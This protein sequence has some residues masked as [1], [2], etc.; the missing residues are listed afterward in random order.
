[1]TLSAVQAHARRVLPVLAALSIAGFFFRFTAPSLNWYFSSDDSM[2]LY[3]S[4]YWPIGSLYRANFLFFLN[5][6]FYRPFVSAWYRLIYYFAG[7]NPVPFHVIVLTMVLANIWLTYAVCRRLTGSREIGALA[8]LLISYHPGFGSLYFDTGFAYDVICYLLYFSAFL[9]YLTMREQSRGPRP[10]QWITFLALYVCALNSKEMAVTLPVCLVIYELLYRKVPWTSARQLG[11]WLKSEG[12]LA[13]AAVLVTLVFVV[14]RGLDR[15]N[16]LLSIQPYVPVFTWDRFMTTSRNFLSGLFIRRH[17]LSAGVLLALWSGMLVTA[18]VSKSRPLRFAWL[19][20][21]LS[22]LPIA[23]IDPRSLAQYYIPF[24]G[25][26]LYAATLLVRSTEFLWRLLPNS[27][28]E[29]FSWLRA[30]ALFLIAGLLL[31]HYYRRLWRED[32]DAIS[33]GPEQQRS[34]VA[35]LH[36]LRP[37]LRHGSRILFLDDPYTD[38]FRMLFLVHLSYRD[39]SLAVDRAKFME[40]FPD[41][42]QI[43]SYDY[44]FDYH[45][46]RFYTSAQRR[47]SGPEPAITMEFGQPDVFHSDFQRVT[48]LSPAKPGEMVISMVK[49]LGETSP[50]IPPGQPFPPDPLLDVV[51][52]V[53]VRVGGQRV[54]VIRKFGWPERVNN[55]RVDFD[56]P[57]D[58]RPGDVNIEII[59]SGVTGP[60]VAIP[61]R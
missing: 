25:W 52:P 42:N 11:H 10:W 38:R 5:S 33:L 51:S 23:F 12:A 49:D 29:Q 40:H 7:F 13:A 4:W 48:R 27:F 1:M 43:A 9:F 46:G 14:G 37:V 54:E 59:A 60:A 28:A 2:N 55:Y 31:L 22:A 20:L 39:S 6:P 58:A 24:F 45:L 17:L 3:R 16:S 44:V 50:K 19:F 35:Q 8:A 41:A 30:S 18:W 53:G 21:I 26:V 34:V 61:V 57:K 36:V 47:P 32:L 15:H 56:I